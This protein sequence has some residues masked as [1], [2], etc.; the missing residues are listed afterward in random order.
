MYLRDSCRSWGKGCFVAGLALLAALSLLGCQRQNSSAPLI[1]NDFESQADLEQISWRCRT[2]F[3]LSEKYR[4]HGQSGLMMTLYPDD[5]PGLRPFL[6]PRLRQWQGYRFLALDVV[7]P[8]NDP[9]K[10][11]YRIDDR[12]TPEYE[13]RVNGTFL[14]EPGVNHLRLDLEQ[15]RTSGSKRPLTLDRI[16]L[17]VFFQVSPTK[18]ITLGIDY[19][20]LENNPP[21]P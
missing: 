11:H 19:L 8:E 15:I 17:L 10:L 7:N 1:L 14:L 18:P 5:Y 2:T 13:D 3:S 12:Q 4:S 21:T 6:P 9:V 20:R 16:Y